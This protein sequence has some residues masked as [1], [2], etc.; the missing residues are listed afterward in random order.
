M[1]ESLFDSHRALAACALAL[2]LAAPVGAA[3]ADARSC[4][5]LDRGGLFADTKISS[6]RLVPE[7][8]GK[9]LPAFC[10]VVGVIAPAPESRIGVVYRLPRNWNGKLL[11]LG[12]GG[13]AGNVTLEIAAP[14][15]TRGYATAQTDG[16]HPGTG[17]R[18]TSW[19]NDTT[20]T[21]FAFRAVHQMTVVGKQV[22]AK[23]YG[24]E[25]SHA[26]FQ[27]CST[28]G[29]QALM[30][31][32][33]YPRD[34]DGVIAGAPV[35]NL[36]T[37]TSAIVRNQAF[38]R[39]GARLTAEHLEALNA[40]ALKACDTKDGLKD[41]IVTDPRLCDF[42]PGALACKDDSKGVC[43]TPPQLA[44]V[45]SMYAGVKTSAGETVSPPL[46]R[47]GELDWGRF[48]AAT[49]PATGSAAVGIDGLRGALFGNPDFDYDS[50]EPDRDYRRA[51]DSAFARLY[52]A[53]DP[54][55]SAF[56]ERGGKLLLWHGWD[57]AGPSPFVTIDYFERM[58]QV[59]APKVDSFD[60]SV[61]FFLAPGVYHCKGGPGA[62]QFDLLGT[63]DAWVDKGTAP[64]SMLATR[65]DGSLSR[66]LCRYPALPRYKGKGKAAEASSFTC[67]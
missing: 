38:S 14:G 18:D 36:I 13:W 16:G 24:R 48:I 54:D 21:D 4:G 15:L 5:A 39:E 2:G 34:Y 58:R 35:Y 3:A 9:N 25:H 53:A 62:D 11:G 10:E 12:G 28:G 42:D 56:I 46:T 50:F 40:A 8:A 33:R 57:D 22:V 30:E 7:D 59:T 1:I 27:G 64:E 65:A 23:Y 37:Q 6:A 47:G 45:R 55:I 43:L 67:R 44:A 19:A 41:G 32:Q 49:G 26:Y 63:I 66:P 51:R 61:R 52:E 20:I 60:E 31:V 29:R 17:L